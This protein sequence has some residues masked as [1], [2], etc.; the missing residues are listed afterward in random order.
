MALAGSTQGEWES[1]LRTAGI[2]D[3]QVTDYTTKV[4]QNRVSILNI[5]EFERQDFRNLEI[6]AIGD[7]K[8]FIQL[9]KSTTINA[10]MDAVPVTAATVKPPV[11]SL[12]HIEVEMTKPQYRKF[13]I[14]W[15]ICK[16][17][18]HTQEDQIHSYLYNCCDPQ[19]QAAL[20]SI[21][22][23]FASATT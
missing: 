19:V 20:V 7:I 10:N 8:N 13:R 14:D 17:S 3:A 12:P 1:F 15:T 18:T 22:N 16:R 9:A 23:E 2:P 5:A 4:L 6:T 21:N 11:A